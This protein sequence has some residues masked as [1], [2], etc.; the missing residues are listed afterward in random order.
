[1]T[2]IEYLQPAGAFVAVLGAIGAGLKWVFAPRIEKAV[3]RGLAPIVE[4]MDGLE[5]RQGKAETRIDGI[6][7]GQERAERAIERIGG[8]IK[9][10]LDGL[11]GAVTKLS[12]SNAQTRESVA[13]I[14]GVLE[15]APRA[16][17]KKS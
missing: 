5:D 9:D 6:E 12:E 10:G 8:E 14:R 2:G 11:A 7:G 13:F 1:M 3:S 15:K 4:R 16:R 17:G